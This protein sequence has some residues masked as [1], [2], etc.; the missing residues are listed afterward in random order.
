MSLMPTSSRSVKPT[1]R[2]R[3]LKVWKETRRSV[4]TC[5]SSLKCRL[6]MRVSQ[7]LLSPRLLVLG[8]TMLCPVDEGPRAAC[9]GSSPRGPP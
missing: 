8:L 5:T 9:P 2:R 3:D 6:C 4:S 7:Q 1:L